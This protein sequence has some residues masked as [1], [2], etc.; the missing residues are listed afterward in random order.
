M[1]MCSC[2]EDLV[3][4]LKRIVFYRKYKELDRLCLIR[5]EEAQKKLRTIKEKDILEAL[6]N[7]KKRDAENDR[8][9]KVDENQ[10]HAKTSWEKVS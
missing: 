9:F 10:V 4:Q 1:K 3:F 2:Y 5:W 8:K 6:E 7:A